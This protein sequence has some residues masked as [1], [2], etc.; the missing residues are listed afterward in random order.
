MLA[1]GHLGTAAFWIALLTLFGWGASAQIPQ[2]PVHR[3]VRLAIVQAPKVIPPPAPALPAPIPVTMPVVPP[4]PERPAPTQTMV[5]TT[6]TLPAHIALPPVRY[7]HEYTGGQ[8]IITKWN[9][10]SLIQ[11]ICADTP[12]AIAC[13]YKTFN[14]ATGKLISCLIMLGPVA[15]DDPKVLRHEIGHCNGWTSAHEGARYD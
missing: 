4:P 5:T 7:D 9:D 13:S 3:P 8:L 1:N 11:H 10:Y 6:P 2:P 12:N 15:H 14:T